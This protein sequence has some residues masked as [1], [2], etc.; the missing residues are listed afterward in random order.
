[1][2]WVQSISPRPQVNNF[3]RDTVP[4]R[5]HL[6][7]YLYQHNV[8]QSETEQ[9]IQLW[10]AFF[11]FTFNMYRYGKK[12]IW[13]NKASYTE[14]EGLPDKKMQQNLQASYR[15]WWAG[16]SILGRKLRQKDWP[17]AHE[18]FP[19]DI[20]KCSKVFFFLLK[21]WIANCWH[22]AGTLPQC[23]RELFWLEPDIPSLYVW[24]WP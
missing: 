12:R 8:L 16:W 19:L 17:G 23:C 10:L 3:S 24:L 11:Y 6:T 13:E 9:R 2:V 4:L 7:Q 18:H 14:S 22:P 5:Q 21:C 1:M 15:T 20:N